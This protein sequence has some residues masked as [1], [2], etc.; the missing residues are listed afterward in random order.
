M[1]NGANGE[2]A[3][4]AECRSGD[5]VP[6]S[7]AMVARSLVTGLQVPPRV[8]RVR[9]NAAKLGFDVVPAA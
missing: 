9:I 7:T 4:E 6:L 2:P 5:T 8:E 1:K 3:C